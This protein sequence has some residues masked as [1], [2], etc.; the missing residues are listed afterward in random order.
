MR[1]QRKVNTRACHSRFK[2]VTFHVRS[3]KW[4]ARIYVD[5]KAIHLGYHAD[6]VEAAKAYDAAARRIFGNFAR[7]NLV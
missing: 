7:P 5:G 6:E 2:G 1:N 3:Q 4:L